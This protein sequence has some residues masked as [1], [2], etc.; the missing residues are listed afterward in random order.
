MADDLIGSFET[1]P[2]PLSRT[3]GI[4]TISV[5][6]SKNHIPV[7]TEVDVTAARAAIR[8][9]KEEGGAVPSFTGWVIKCLAQAVGEHKRVHAMRR[10]R[11][12]LILFDDVDVYVVVERRVAG[13]DPPETLPMPYV[14]RKAN[15]KSVEDIHN[16]IRAAQSHPLAAGEQVIA[17]GRK[18]APWRMRLFPSL[19]SF[20][21]RR[22]VFDRLVADPFYAK[23]TM[24]TV[25]V[26]SIGMYGEVGGGGSW[27]VPIGIAPLI[28]AL[29][30]IARKPG[31]VDE[32][33]EIR[34]ILGMTILFDHDVID[35]AP[36]A[37][38]IQ[39]LRDLLE[40]AFSL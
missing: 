13:G 19:P 8:R 37:V 18:A 31:V 34:E 39:R 10:R 35:G 11:K 27:P 25:G 23:R 12:S 29:G 4:D 30:A 5:G 6:K 3:L 15:E 36:V 22:L 40:S 32:R 16:E 33:V 9:R 38:F 24:G 17:P 26:T 7:L 21:R 28:V 2:F 14:L 1:R 20:V